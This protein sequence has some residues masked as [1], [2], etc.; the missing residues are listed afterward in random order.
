MVVIDSTYTEE[1]MLR[2]R[3]WHQR[4]F[5]LLRH[6]WLITGAT[7]LLAGLVYV[8][9]V[10]ILG[11]VLLSYGGYSLLRNGMLK[12]QFLKTMRCSPD[13]GKGLIW[14][15]SEQR[16]VQ[17]KGDS[18]AQISWSS[19]CKSLITPEGVLIY[20]RKNAYFWLPTAALPKGEKEALHSVIKSRTRAK[21]IA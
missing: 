18:A 20:V 11:L 4:Q 8:S 5:G 14:I 16:I 2:A 1:E 6:W 3:G 12:S 17:E 9:T 7:G 10:P 19:V 13:L 15:I 21:V